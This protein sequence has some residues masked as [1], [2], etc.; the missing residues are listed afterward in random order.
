MAVKK[1]ERVKNK[2]GFKMTFA[3]WPVDK[4]TADCV[5]FC[6]ILSGSLTGF[7]TIFSSANWC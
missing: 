1:S 6:M 7:L 4:L 2:L 5:L 3:H